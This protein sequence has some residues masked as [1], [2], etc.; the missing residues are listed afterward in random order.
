MSIIN[1]YVNAS[2]I[3]GVTDNA[4]FTDK[5]YYKKGELLLSFMDSLAQFIPHNLEECVIWEV[6]SDDKL[7]AY[8]EFFQEDGYKCKLVF[9]NTLVSKLP[10]KDI[11]CRLLAYG[12]ESSYEM[13]ARLVNMI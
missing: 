5:I 11:V 8:F 2:L 1:R 4:F 6:T 10:G 7:I 12:W 13:Y 9:N 3:F